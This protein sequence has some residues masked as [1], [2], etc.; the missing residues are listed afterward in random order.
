[1]KKNAI[2]LLLLLLCPAIWAQS[3]SAS[4]GFLRLPASARLA[5]MGGNNISFVEDA[6]WAGYTNPALYANVSDNSLGLHFMTYAAGSQLM[7]AEFV[8]AFGDRHT[9]AITA[10]LMNYGS[11]D[12]TDG[13]GNTIGSFSAKDISIGAAYSYLMSERW[14]GGAALNFIYSGY[15]DYNA[16]ALSINLGLN[17]YDEDSDF[18]L[19]ATASHIGFQMSTFDG[20]AEK[21]P[22]NLQVGFT[23][24]M[25]HLPVRFSV[26]MTD[27][28]RWKKNYYFN[29]DD[30]D[31]GFGK[32]LL[33]HF[34][35]GLDVQPIDFLYL[36]AGY[37]FRRA[38]ELKAA[39]SGHGA[40]LSFGGGFMLKRFKA[41]ISY[42]KYHVSTASLMFNAGYNF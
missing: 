37:N 32:L 34:V 42:A 7:G 14:T 35:V 9:G 2:T 23:K 40:G 5:A 13:Q 10:Q 39:G 11:M 4:F 31:L 8:K 27:L 26:S 20:Y 24:G 21:L 3:G 6:P 28:T 12:E 22:F 41:G 29:G 38:H 18:S 17:Y 16:T 30:G 33:N 19:S 36:S 15:A 25:N 1:M